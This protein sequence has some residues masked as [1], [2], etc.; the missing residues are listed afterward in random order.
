L[1]DRERQF[2]ADSSPRGDGVVEAKISLSWGVRMLIAGVAFVGFGVWSLYDGQVK[3]PKVE[4][5]FQEFFAEDRLEEWVSFAGEKG[6]K[7]EWKKEADTGRAHVYSQWDIRTQFIMAAACLPIGLGIL[8]RLVL[9]VPR[10]MEADEEG[11]TATDGTRIPY[12]AITS[13]DRRKWDR[14]GIAVVHYEIDGVPAKTKIDDWI[15]KGGAD[16]LRSIDE[17]VPPEISGVEPEPEADEEADALLEDIDIEESVADELARRQA[18]AV[19]DDAEEDQGPDE[20]EGRGTEAEGGG[21][22]RGAQP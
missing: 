7:K 19:P 16:I 20:A 18:G 17:H 1:V 11:F 12:P 8:L 5:A 14:K 21:A 6:W 3:Y 10:R 4:A 15:F 22:G 2:K 13:I 9:T